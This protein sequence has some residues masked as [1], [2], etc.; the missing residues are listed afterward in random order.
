MSLSAN[1][2]RA[3]FSKRAFAKVREFA[4]SLW[5]SPA[6]RFAVQFVVLAGVLLAVYY[7]PY[8]NDSRTKSFFDSYLHAYAALAGGVLH[9][10]EPTLVVRGQEIIGRYSLR[11]I[12]TC[13]A[14]DTQILLASAILSWPASPR[15]RAIA[16][17]CGVVAMAMLNVF[18][19]CSLYYVGLFFPTMFDFAH[20]ELWPAVIVLSSVAGFVAFT[21][22]ARR[23]ELRSAG[24]Q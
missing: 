24:A 3:N 15:F 7:F 22:W 18:R 12:K 10:F 9:W 19:I 20:L 14:M 2:D 21:S 8:S 16:A 23:H 1:M 6:R 5:T 4:V 17:L 11:I 13:D